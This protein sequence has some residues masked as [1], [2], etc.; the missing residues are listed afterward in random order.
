M[1]GNQKKAFLKR[2]SFFGFS[3]SYL[4]ELFAGTSSRV[5][6]GV[7]RF[8]KIGEF[9]DVSGFLILFQFFAQFCVDG[10]L[11]LVGR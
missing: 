7:K 5:R 8:E 2:A 4:F 10:S 3:R 1:N 9:S 11:E 6:G